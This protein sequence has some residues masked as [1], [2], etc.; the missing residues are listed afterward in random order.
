MIRSRWLRRVSFL[1]ALGTS[2]ALTGCADYI[3]VSDLHL[4]VALA[5]DRTTDGATQVTAEIVNPQSAP[6]MGGSGGGSPQGSK[7]YLVATAIGNSVEQAVSEL[8]Q[9]L[10]YH[11]YLSHNTV[12]VFGRAYLN[13]GIEQALDYLERNRSFRRSEVLVAT[14]GEAR[15]VLNLSTAPEPLNAFGIRSLVD[16]TALKTP[17]MGSEQLQ[18]VDEYLSPSHVSLM[19]W[20]D[21]DQEGQPQMKGVALLENGR[22]ARYLD[23]RDTT[24]LAWVL[25]STHEIDIEVPCPGE[26]GPATAAPSQPRSATIRLL[27]THTEITPSVDERDLP[28]IRISVRGRGEIVRLCSNEAISQELLAHLGQAA[29]SV[30]RSRIVHVTKTLQRWDVD[31]A[32]FSSC[33]YRRYPHWWKEHRARWQQ[34]FPDVPVTVDVQ[35]SVARSGLI[36]HSVDLWNKGADRPPL[37]RGPKE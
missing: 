36:T 15:T 27:T 31:A 23:W 9:T 12:V 28:R 20:I 5:I 14:A 17:A 16:R 19:A 24:A 1:F 34:I 8:D 3:D 6:S 2:L 26:P 25:G 18:I 32:Q 7:P 33:L 13:Q 4:V 35:I 22:L 29:D 30:I 10:P 11:L 21:G 37:S